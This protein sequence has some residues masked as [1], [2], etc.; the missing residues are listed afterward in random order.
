MTKGL[1]IL[2]ILTL[3]CT[4]PAVTSCGRSPRVTFYSLM[5]KVESETAVTSKAAASVLVAQVTL[6]EVVDRP[7][8]V[9]RV[10][11]NRVEILETHRWAEPLKS[12]IPRL[13]AENLGQ[14]LGSDK[15][16]SYPQNISADAD[17]RVSMDIQRFEC[18]PGE[19]V[20]I[21]AHWMI[22]RTAGGLSKKGHS[23]IH[24]PVDKQ[25]RESQVDAYSRALLAVSRE[26]AETIRGMESVW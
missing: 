10:G 4:L 12:E 26:M 18:T 5:P 8:L 9:E 6:P 20:T 22:R 19:K 16:W 24:E 15:V 7:Q 21:D 13:V 17:Y 3:C 23:V 14:L 25:G 11:A 2:G 1:Y